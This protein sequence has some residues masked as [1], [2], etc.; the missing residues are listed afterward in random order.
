MTRLDI[1]KKITD[2]LFERGLVLS[3]MEIEPSSPEDM[4]EVAFYLDDGKQKTPYK[5][6]FVRNETNPK[7]KA[8]KV[9]LDEIIHGYYDSVNL[10]KREDLTDG[11][12]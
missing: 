9:L 8:F 3:Y 6:I 1:E 12:R 10:G 5:K 11:F 7:R 2:I 4:Y